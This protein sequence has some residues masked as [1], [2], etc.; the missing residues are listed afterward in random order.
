MALKDYIDTSLLKN[1]LLEYLKWLITKIYYQIKYWGKHVRIGYKAVIT[2]CKFGHYSWVTQ[3]V[4]MENSEL[5]D[6]S[7]VSNDSVILET[8][9]GKFCS[10][11]PNVKS[12]PGNHP[13]KIIV[14][15]YPP[16]YSNPVISLKN[17][18][19]KDY[20]APERAVVIGN[21]VWICANVVI[22]GGVTIGDGAI[23]AAN[24]VVLKDVE[25]FAIV[26]GNPAVLIRHR[27]SEQER[28][29]LNEIKWWDKDIHWFE[30]NWKNMLNIED[31]LNENQ[32]KKSD[33]EV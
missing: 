29:Q 22:N 23:V 6:F 30:K 16:L 15:T 13:S 5:G 12:S 10:I 11:G 25:P 2:N 8:K 18:A 31:F 28:H 27:F 17:F 3:N 19:D 26:G 32:K 14:S 1:P 33:G 24:S 20:H 21:D 7:Y 4:I 9:I